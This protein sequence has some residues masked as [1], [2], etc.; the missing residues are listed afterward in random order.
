MVGTAHPTVNMEHQIKL[1]IATGNTGKA[2]EIT[3]ELAGVDDI[4][5]LSLRDFP[6]VEECEETGTTFEENAI[7]KAKYYAEKFKVLTLADDSGLEVDAL[8]G[9]PGV[10]SARYAGT[11]CDDLANNAKLVQSLAGVPAE[12]RTA[13]FRCVMAMV[14]SDGKLLGTACGKIEG[15]IID[16]P[17]GQNGFGYDPHFFMDELGKT[18]AEIS[19]A[20]KNKISHRG[21]ATGAMRTLLEKLYREKKL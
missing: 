4:Q 14:D 16:E 15:R 6:P 17:R 5:C 12:Q 9:E 18:T 8:N 11:P 2:A 13:R 21:Q 3:A 19:S 10:Y 20:E 7:L 1:L